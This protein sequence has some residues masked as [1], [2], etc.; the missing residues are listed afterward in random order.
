MT[1]MITT[2]RSRSEEFYTAIDVRNGE[3]IRVHLKLLA[4]KGEEFTH[5]HIP[6][7]LKVGEEGFEQNL[8]NAMLNISRCAPSEFKAM[9]KVLN[10]NG[11]SYKL[12]QKFHVD[13]NVELP[14]GH[15]MS[16]LI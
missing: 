14:Q 1:D 10:P 15:Q 13:E 8:E 16:L 4:Q 3:A 6:T 9:C 5:K 11:S 7:I 12:S 2:Y